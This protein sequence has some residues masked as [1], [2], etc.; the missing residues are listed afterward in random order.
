MIIRVLLNYRKKCPCLN[1][2]KRYKPLSLMSWLETKQDIQE[3]VQQFWIQE[4]EPSPSK[5]DTIIK[6]FNGKRI[7]LPTD[8]WEYVQKRYYQKNAETLFE[9]WKTEMVL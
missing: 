4:S 5:H 1:T 9:D 6:K 2:F 7:K 8:K 3:S